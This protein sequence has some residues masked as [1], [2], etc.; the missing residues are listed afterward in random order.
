MP[1]PDVT[2]ST[3]L[4][5]C[6]SVRAADTC[7]SAPH[8]YKRMCCGVLQCVAARCSVLQCVAVWCSVVQCV[9]ARCSVLQC[10]YGATQP[11]YRARSRHLRANIKYV[12]ECVAVCCSVL[13]CSVVW[14]SVAGC[15]SVWQCVAVANYLRSVEK[16]CSSY[17]S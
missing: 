15:G 1:C 5:D 12:R 11:H 3:G 7:A 13:Q 4:R 16:C 8:R 17:S 6:S 2:A 10:V 9:A 14:C